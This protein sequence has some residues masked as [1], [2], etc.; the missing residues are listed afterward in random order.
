MLSIFGWIERLFRF[1]RKHV[2]YV[3]EDPDNL[4]YQLTKLPTCP[5]FIPDNIMSL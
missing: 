3:A 5:D 2:A 4:G 1:D